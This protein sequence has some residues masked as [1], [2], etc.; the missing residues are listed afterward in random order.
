MSILKLGN[1]KTYESTTSIRVDCNVENDI[2]WI[3]YTTKDKN[4]ADAYST[5]RWLEI[6][7]EICKQ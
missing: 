1:Y 7:N 2:I 4:R 5:K 6:M 3:Q